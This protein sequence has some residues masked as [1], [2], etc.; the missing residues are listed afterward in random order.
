MTATLTI[1]VAG[2]TIPVVCAPD[3]DHLSLRVV[4]APRI[5]ADAT[6]LL[7]FQ[8]DRSAATLDIVATSD[9]LGLGDAAAQTAGLLPVFEFKGGAVYQLEVPVVAAHSPPDPAN[10]H[11]SADHHSRH[12][13]IPS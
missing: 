2:S 7:G 1:P 3:P 6:Y 8:R 4:S 11:P 13:D 12:K 10:L 9:W 5:L